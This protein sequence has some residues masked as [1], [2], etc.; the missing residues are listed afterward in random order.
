[1]YAAAGLADLL[2]TIAAEE[3]AAA[4]EATG[5]RGGAANSSQGPGDAG[6]D[7]CP[8]PNLAALQH[9][10]N[11]RRV[12]FVMKALE[13]HQ[14]LVDAPAIDPGTADLLVRVRTLL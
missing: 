14:R 8:E 3:V 9:R 6:C 10:F 2:C 7:E 12:L 13:D 11:L 5:A 4:E 1:M